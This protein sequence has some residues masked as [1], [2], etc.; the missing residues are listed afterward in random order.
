M[1]YAAWSV[2]FGEQPS[3]AKWN[4]L[5]SNDA[6]FNDGTGIA[7]LALNTTAI[8]NPYKFRGYRNS[9]QNTASGSYTVILCD[10][11]DYDTNN[12]F[13]IATN[14][15]RYT[16]PVSGFY[17]FNG[18]GGISA[19]SGL[20]AVEVA[21]FKNGVACSYGQISGNTASTGS[22]QS[23]VSDMVQLSAGDYM[24]LQIYCNATTAMVVGSAAAFFGGYLVSK[25]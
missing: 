3:A 1:T 14:K 8:S 20:T 17:Q 21:L 10:A 11:E 7:N 6:S 18:A 19:S 2:I 13:D 23:T 24:E 25:T 16:A 15:G 22:V 12:N 4:V 5:G 9:A